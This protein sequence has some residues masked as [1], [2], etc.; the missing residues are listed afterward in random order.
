MNQMEIGENREC[1]CFH[2][3]LMCFRF[4]SHGYVIVELTKAPHQ[5]STYTGTTK[6]E[7]REARNEDGEKD[8]VILVSKCACFHFCQHILFVLS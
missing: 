2:W 5:L 6:H 7:E 4:V 1:V 3:F 8:D